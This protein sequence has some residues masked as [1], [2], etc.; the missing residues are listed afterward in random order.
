MAGGA[1]GAHARTAAGRAT[2]MGRQTAA[3]RPTGRCLLARPPMDRTTT[4]SRTRG[5][6]MAEQKCVRP[7][8]PRG[9]DGALRL[10]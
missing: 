3:A 5:M 10:P 1:S 4:S 8:K 7:S 6:T 9:T 2:P